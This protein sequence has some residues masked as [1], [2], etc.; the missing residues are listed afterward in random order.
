M[1]E[2]IQYILAITWG[3]Q[4]WLIILVLAL[5]ILGGK[6]LPELARSIGKSLTA[7]RKGIQEAEQTKDEL[8]NDVKKVKDDIVNETK[9][10][11]GVNDLEKNQ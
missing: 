2:N 11:A 1:T 6:R 7:L 10:A 8:L 3:W 4:E 5:L 9:D